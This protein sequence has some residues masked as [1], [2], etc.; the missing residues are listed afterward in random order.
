MKQLK[1]IVCHSFVLAVLAANFYIVDSYAAGNISGISPV[2]GASLTDI[3]EAINGS[4]D[5]S[6]TN[7]LHSLLAETYAIDAYTPIMSGQQQNL[8]KFEDSVND[9]AY[10]IISLKISNLLG[11]NTTANTNSATMSAPELEMLSTISED[12]PNPHLFNIGSLLVPIAYNDRTDSDLHSNNVTYPIST[13]NGVIDLLD[14]YA[15]I[16][17]SI[18]Y[19][20][21]LN[22][23]PE[24]NDQQLEDPSNGPPAG[25]DYDQR[26]D[27]TACIKN[28]MGRQYEA[29]RRSA[30]LVKSIAMYNFYRMLTQRK[31]VRQLVSDANS[32]QINNTNLD[33]NFS[34]QADKLPDKIKAYSPKQIQ[35]YLATW[36]LSSKSWQKAIKHA[37]SKDLLREIVLLLA[38]QKH[39]D[40]TQQQQ[41]ER[42]L[43]TLSMIALNTIDL[44][45]VSKAKEKV[46]TRIDD[47]LKRNTCGDPNMNLDAQTTNSSEALKQTE[48]L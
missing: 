15:A 11:E 4:S 1:K 18:D 22:Y 33:Q 30:I 5:H 23:D 13:A 3:L 7:I 20:R 24:E 21:L 17:G 39:Q 25:K 10:S 36:R 45:Q 38:E 19:S 31:T 48:N 40:Y 9:I 8:L 37:N 2:V 29:L 26:N 34:E 43:A 41:M 32:A 16:P 35:H 28:T 42:I 44:T 47:A 27:R 12:N 46:N 6:L 14:R